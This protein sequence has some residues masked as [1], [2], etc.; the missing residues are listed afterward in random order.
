VSKAKDF[1]KGRLKYEDDGAYFATGTA[2]ACLWPKSNAEGLD[3]FFEVDEDKC[4]L[5]MEGDSKNH[6]ALH[7]AEEISR[8][9]PAL[10]IHVGGSSEEDRS[11]LWEVVNGDGRLLEESD[12][13]IFR[14][15]GFGVA[16][17]EVRDGKEVSPDQRREWILE[18]VRKCEEYARKEHS[19]EYAPSERARRARIIDKTI[20][21]YEEY[22][23]LRRQ[24]RDQED[25]IATS[26]LASH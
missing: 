16:F 21:E 8:R 25:V 12:T 17:W 5:L 19:I 6:P 13:I 9:F 24:K 11:E 23:R 14:E 3:R 26:T 10:R 4:V 20:A 1:I 15:L 22:L 2:W 7:V 18:D